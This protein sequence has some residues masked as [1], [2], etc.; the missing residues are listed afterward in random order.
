[1]ENRVLEHHRPIY[2]GGKNSKS[3]VSW[4]CWDCNTRK[5]IQTY[6]EFM[7]ETGRVEAPGVSAAWSHQGGPDQGSGAVRRT[8][9]RSAGALQ[10]SEVAVCSER[11]DSTLGPD[12]DGAAPA[13]E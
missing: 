1:M 10:P 2:R 4:A 7:A 9:A 13:K 12:G 6:D 11:A 8:E 3:N 5:G